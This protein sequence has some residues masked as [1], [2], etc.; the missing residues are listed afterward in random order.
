ML[1]RII[2][3]KVSDILG[4]TLTSEYIGMAPNTHFLEVWGKM[5][6][7]S[8]LLKKTPEKRQLQ[9]K[10]MKRI[11]MQKEKHDFSHENAKSS[12]PELYNRES[13]HHQGRVFV[14]EFGEKRRTTLALMKKI[15]N[16]SAKKS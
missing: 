7:T 16:M 2:L 10:K 3:R 12:A 5:C 1:V 8:V 13:N 4:R 15:E 14:Q 11:I 6:K 9:G